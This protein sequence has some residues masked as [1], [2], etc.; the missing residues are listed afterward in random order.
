MRFRVI[1]SL[2]LVVGA[3]AHPGG[4][5]APADAERLVGTWRLVEVVAVRNDGTT[6][7]SR[8]GPNPRGYIVYDRSGHM[9]A[10]M[11]LAQAQ[12]GLV[13]FRVAHLP[14]FVMWMHNST[15]KTPRIAPS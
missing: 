2:A 10:R 1:V 9:A 11:S 13:R 15:L 3:C 7:T 6:T 5:G 4:T 14:A 8:W 12:V